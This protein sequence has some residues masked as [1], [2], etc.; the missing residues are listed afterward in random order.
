MG[1][2]KPKKGAVLPVLSNP[3]SENE[4]VWQYQA[5]GQEG[6]IIDGMLGY[7]ENPYEQVVNYTMLYDEGNE[8]TDI[9]G[10]YIARNCYK[11]DTY[12]GVL[13][14][15]INNLNVVHNTPSGETGPSPINKINLSGYRG[16][17]VLIT[18]GVTNKGTWCGAWFYVGDEQ[19]NRLMEPYRMGAG[20]TV[21]TPTLYKMYF[22]NGITDAYIT[23]AINNNG[24]INL[25][26]MLL[27]KTDDWTTL[28]SK[29]FINPTT[30]DNLLSNSAT[31]LSNEDAVWFMVK[32]C[33]GEF[34][35]TAIQNSTFM[36]ALDSSPYK[37]YILSNEHWAKA[38]SMVA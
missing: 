15:N 32:Q 11:D 34:M 35:F 17:C 7:D 31:I 8:C 26:S 18:Y 20:N 19:K 9:T 25:F 36:T 22:D 10:G 14:K 23:P 13:T 16:V 6:Q 3:A 30:I 21:N 4:I 2:I 37:N 33:T 38:L 12:A 27:F 1:L 29:C 24:N 5:I 28:A